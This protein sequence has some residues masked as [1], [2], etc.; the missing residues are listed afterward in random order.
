M[1]LFWG[2]DVSTINPTRSGGVWILR[3]YIYT[4]FLHKFLLSPRKSNMTPIP[5]RQGVAPT[6]IVINGV[7][8]MGPLEMAENKWV[9]LGL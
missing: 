1:I 8:D 5:I 2:W 6:T 3:V 9:S 4:M 7:S